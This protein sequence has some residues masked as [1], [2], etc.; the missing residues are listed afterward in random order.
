MHLPCIG[1]ASVIDETNTSN[2]IVQQ[3]TFELDERTTYDFD[4]S[5]LHRNDFF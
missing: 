4:D 1:V 2:N 3:P 5:W